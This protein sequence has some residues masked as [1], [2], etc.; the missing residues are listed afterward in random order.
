MIPNTQWMKE[1]FS[2]YNQKYFEN[3]LPVPEFAVE[4]LNGIWGAY[5][6]NA[7][8]SRRSRKIVNVRGNGKITLTNARERNEKS[9]IN[10]LLHEMTHEYVYLVMGIYPMD[11]HGKEFMSVANKINADGWN[12]AAA[13]AERSVEDTRG[14]V[15]EYPIICII[16]NPSS[17]SAKWWICRAEESNMQQFV[18][19]AS[20]ITGAT[21]A[22]FYRVK[23]C[24]SLNIQ[25]NPSTLVGYGGG[26]Y[27]EAA[28]K[29][30]D[31]CRVSPSLF[32]GKNLIPIK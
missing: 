4:R 23:G 27:A 22:K 5:D 31:F 29:M 2:L 1:K 19:A 28:K 13:T 3:R 20:K 30:A 8:F 24:S 18:T 10:T 17:K 12:I 6:L 21:G 16:Q 7:Q 25:S 15:P 14:K 11:K 9:V 32:S 26:S